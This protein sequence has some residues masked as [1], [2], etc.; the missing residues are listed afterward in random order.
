LKS[1]VALARILVTIPAVFLAIGPAIADLNAT[2][3]A[4][5]LWPGHARLHTVW[6]LCT[7]S[8]VMWIALAVLWSDI[9][10]PTQRAV[11]LASA[12]VG[13]VLFGFFAAAASQSAYGGSLTDPNGIPF[14]IGGLDANLAVFSAWGVVLAVAIGLAWSSTSRDAA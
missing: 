14:R 2:H 9:Q 4:N 8:L 13:S 5:P 7:N 1:R 11:L 6:L 3:V 12:L 10:A